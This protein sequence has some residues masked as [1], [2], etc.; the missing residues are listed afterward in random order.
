M[1][2]ILTYS[3]D[4]DDVFSVVSLISPKRAVGAYH[5]FLGYSRGDKIKFKQA[6]KSDDIDA[7]VI[8]CS[9]LFDIIIFQLDTPIDIAPLMFW[10]ETAPDGQIIGAEY[11][12]IV[13]FAIIFTNRTR[14]ACRLS[15]STL[16]IVF[17]LNVF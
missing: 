16:T 7:V 5:C 13:R 12:L 17:L 1:K 8:F 11:F 14:K 4:G 10:N 6:Y 2:F 3:D 15:I 9:R